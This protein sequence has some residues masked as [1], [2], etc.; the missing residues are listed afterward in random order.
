[1]EK[2]Y[3]VEFPNQYKRQKDF[4]CSLGF[5]MTIIG[6]KWRAILLWHILKAE[7][8]RYGELKKSIPHISHKVF[9]QNLKYLEMD[10]LIQRI[11]YDSNPPNVE[12]LATDRGKSLEGILSDLCNWGKKYMNS[13]EL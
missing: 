2:D 8:V 12:Y 11:V 9:S 7:T 13:D 4:N 5:A 10:G 6:N 1:M 3:G